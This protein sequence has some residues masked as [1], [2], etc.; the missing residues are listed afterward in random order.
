LRQ[1]VWLY[2]KPAFVDSIILCS[3]LSVVDKSFDSSLSIDLQI[4][5]LPP[6][7]AYWRTHSH[8][9]L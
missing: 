5:W 2:R 3:I 8:Q 9:P 7:L 4:R 6:I 1:N